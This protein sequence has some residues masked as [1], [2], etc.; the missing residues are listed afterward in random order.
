GEEVR[1]ADRR[2]YRYAVAEPCSQHHDVR[3]QPVR[4]EREQVAGPAEV[5]LH[6]IKDENQIMLPAEPLQELEIRG[7]R[8]VRSAAAEVRLGDETAE[9]AA[10]LA[11]QGVEFLL[12]RRRV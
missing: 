12:I 11:V 10:V 1:P 4:L 3:L 5:R 9:L 8:V 7:R 2:R 6:L